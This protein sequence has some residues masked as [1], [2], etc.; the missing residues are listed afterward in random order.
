MIHGLGGIR[1]PSIAGEYPTIPPINAI[2]RAQD[3]GSDFS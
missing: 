2:A 3:I 1:M